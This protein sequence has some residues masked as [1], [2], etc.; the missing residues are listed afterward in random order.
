MLIPSNFV[1]KNGFPVV[2]LNNLKYR[3]SVISFSFFSSISR[4]RPIRNTVE[5][6]HF[7]LDFFRLSS[8]RVFLPIASL[9]PPP[10]THPHAHTP[11][12]GTTQQR[13]HTYTRYHTA[14]SYNSAEAGLAIS[15]VASRQKSAWRIPSSA[16][17][18]RVSPDGSSA[19]YRCHF[20]NNGYV[21]CSF[22][23]SR[24]SVKLRT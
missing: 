10:N 5:K 17:Q 18:R 23:G 7:R 8:T 24:L 1:H 6:E 13:P 9:V 16:R 21:C 15:A 14:V 12:P 4:P 2:K 20:A 11:I 22:G 3:W 19:R